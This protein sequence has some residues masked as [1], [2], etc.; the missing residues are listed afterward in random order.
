MQVIISLESMRDR[1]DVSG[2]VGQFWSASNWIH[3]NL[4]KIQ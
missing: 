2:E 1:V 4:T 3:K